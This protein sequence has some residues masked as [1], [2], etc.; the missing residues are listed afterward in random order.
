ME[1][2][3]A[4][5]VS[6]R[7][8]AKSFG[9]RSVL[10]GVD[11]DVAPGEIVGLLGRNGAGKSTLI[12]IMCGL[13]RADA[14]AVSVCG[15]DPA[16]ECVGDCIG[17]TP[18]DIGVYPQLTVEQNLVCFGGIEG[19]SGRDARRRAHEVMELLGLLPQARQ[20]ARDL[21]GGQRRRLHTGIALMH[22]PRVV[23]LDEPTVGADVEARCGVLAAVRAVAAAGS[24]VVYTTH[25]LGELE[26]LGA[27]I[28]VLDQ[29]H[30]VVSG[31]L[32]EVVNAYARPS[33]R[34][35]FKGGADP[36]VPGW[37]S[38]GGGYLEPKESGG[39]PAAC[40]AQLLGTSRVSGF[41]LDDV[42]V[43]HADLESAYLAIVG[44]Q[45]IHHA[46]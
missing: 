33:V 16:H 22:R 7:G 8:V 30:I 9:A 11:L 40:L 14:G 37:R 44:E 38:V 34:V 5:A 4:S 17:Y 43:M 23:F 46:A 39:D 2:S 19:L 28:A 6:L 12:S 27:N 36:G 45:V 35:R 31:R 21:S 29:G 15:R 1:V 18:Q 26:E 20:R 32:S 42:R 25:Y 41:V 13:A 3:G 24:A 10:R